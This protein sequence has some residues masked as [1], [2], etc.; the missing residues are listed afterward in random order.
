MTSRYRRLAF[1]SDVLGAQERYGSRPALDRLD[2]VHPG[3]EAPMPAPASGDLLWP[4]ER[5][6]LGELDEFYVATVSSTGWPYAQLRGGPPGF[7]RTPD[8]RTIAWAD[9][10]GNRQYISVGNLAGDARVALI[11]LD[12]PRQLR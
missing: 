3:R 2:R 11:F 10:R 1:T 7:I 4:D 12:H 5:A 8:E 9:F 6:F